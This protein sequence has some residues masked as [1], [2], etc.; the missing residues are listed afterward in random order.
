M[1]AT[2]SGMG[3]GG[4][5]RDYARCVY[6]ESRGNPA[7]ALQ[8]ATAVLR[9]RAKHGIGPMN[10]SLFR[11]SGVPSS[12]W[13]NYVTDKQF[14]VRIFKKHVP[15]SVN[16][17]VDNK[18]LFYQHCLAN[19]LPTIPII[20]GLGQ[21]PGHAPDGVIAHV[22]NFDQWEAV[23]RSSTGDIFIKPMYGAHGEGT[24]AVRRTGQGLVFGQ[25]GV[26][27]DTSQGL[28][29]CM[30]ERLKN[31]TALL[32]QPRVR[33]HRK[34][35]E[36]SSANGLSTAR[37]VTA[38]TENR[39]RVIFAVARL[40]AGA[41]IT[42]NFSRGASGNLAV[43]IDIATGTL[44]EAWR[45]LRSDWPIMQSTDLHPDT[46][47]R[48]RGAVFPLWQDVVDLAL[49][50]QNSMPELRTVGWDIA[51]TDEGALLV[52]ANCYY[53]VALL[54]VV[55]QHGLWRELTKFYE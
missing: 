5:L 33:V 10:Y 20:C 38:F 53:S 26:D 40:S 23:L 29:C 14:Y 47:R 28:Y 27:G 11:F 16:R 35:L 4:A 13:D 18:V 12:R 37:I 34:L 24:L 19:G 7:R 46:G 52:E 39:A 1:N 21:L 50:A 41:N 54:E 6:L 3:H 17:L 36:I 9:A 22:E 15:E 31:E 32:V 42:D 30:L 2:R 25:G 51:V 44:S 48:I 8:V 49:R 43:A 45:S 55:Y